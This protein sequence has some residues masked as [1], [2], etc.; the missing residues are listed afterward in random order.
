MDFLIFIVVVT[1]VGSFKVGVL[2]AFL[3]SLVLAIVGIYILPLLLMAVVG[4]IWTPVRKVKKSPDPLLSAKGVKQTQLVMNICKVIGY[5]I[6]I[7]TLVIYKNG[8]LL[9]AGLAGLMVYFVVSFMWG[10]LP[11]QKPKNP[12]A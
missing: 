8:Q 11:F 12:L 1:V 3:F 6:L 2:G 4:L 9:V 10:D 7:A 5:I